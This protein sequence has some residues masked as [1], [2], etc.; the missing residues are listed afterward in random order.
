[1]FQQDNDPK[2]TL[3]L[4]WH[5]KK[6]GDIKLLTW[7]SQ[8][9]NLNPNENVGTT[10]KSNSEWSNIQLRLC[11]TLVNGCQEHLTEMQFTKDCL[12]KY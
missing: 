2:R 6:Q 3:Q 5:L 12:A 4:G 7:P 11:Q 9:S 10:L 1:M 8:S